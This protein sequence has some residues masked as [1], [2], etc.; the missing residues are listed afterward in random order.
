VHGLSMEGEW[1]SAEVRWFGLLPT[2]PRHA[3][4]RESFV[5]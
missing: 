1:I 4:N 3:S 5:I 2:C